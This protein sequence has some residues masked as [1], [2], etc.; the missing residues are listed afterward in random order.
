[1]IG[2]GRCKHPLDHR[3]IK[4]DYRSG[5]KIYTGNEICTCGRWFKND[6]AMGMMAPYDYEMVDATD[7]CIVSGC[8]VKLCKGRE[9]CDRHLKSY[10]L[11]MDGRSRRSMDDVLSGRG[12]D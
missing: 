4:V 10:M 5:R 9:L 7:L 2:K 12:F 1:M 6:Q 11:A 3:T 8:D